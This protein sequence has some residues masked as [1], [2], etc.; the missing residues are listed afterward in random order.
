MIWVDRLAAELSW[1]SR[2]LEISWNEI[3]QRLGVKLPEDFK[4]FCR[5][6]GVGQFI[7]YLE[8]YSSSGGESL[9]ILDKLH[10]F[11][12]MLER[13]L[14]VR[15][16]YEPYGL[17]RPDGGGL[18]P[19][20]VSE[21]AAEFY[22]LVRDGVQSCDWPVLARQEGGEW[23]VHEMSMSEFTYRMLLDVAFDGFTIAD[24]VPDP[25]YDAAS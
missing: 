3:E 6:F 17:F 14:V 23:K 24:L 16:V 1:Q 9:R 5:C 22:W 25:F 4:V 8:I 13:H 15:G 19:W 11:R 2:E 18:L 7:G 20:G 10:R 12:Q 21:T